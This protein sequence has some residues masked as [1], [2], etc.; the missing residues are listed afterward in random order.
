M[1]DRI[2]QRWGNYRLL[3]LLG[4]G[5]F[6][7]VYLGAHLRL[8]TNAAIKILAT[9]L[10][11]DDQALLFAEAR[12]I[13]RLEHPHI[14][15]ILDFDVENGVPFIVMSYAP[16][17][18]LRQRFPRGTRLPLHLI[19]T[20]LK[21]LADALQ[22]AHEARLI[23]RD[24][25]PENMLLGAHNEILLSD[26]GVAIAARSSH[27]QTLQEI[28]G[29]VTYMAPEQIQGKPRPASDQYALGVIA[30]EWLTGQPPFRGH[31]AEVATQHMFAVPSPPHEQQPEISEQ[32]EAVILKALAKDPHQRFSDVRAFAEA[33][34]Q[35][36][37]RFLSSSNTSLTLPVR[38]E[39]ASSLV[40]LP[41]NK[42][43]S[44]APPQLSRRTI[45]LGSAALAVLVGAGT[46]IAW[47]TLL[48]HTP[49]SQIPQIQSQQAT[50][51]GTAGIG[52]RLITYKGH[53]SPVRSM[54]WSPDDQHI[55]SG[56]DF[57]DRTAQVWNPNTGKRVL[58][59]VGQQSEIQALAWS[60]A[61]Q[62][63]ASGCGN[64]L[65]QGEHTVHIWSAI[66]GKHIVTYTGHTQPIMAVAWSPDGKTVA[67]AGAD[68]T[69]QIW[70]TTSAKILRIYTGHQDSVHA[71]AWSS[72]GK[73]IASASDD[74]TV[75]I[76]NAQ[77]AAHLLTLTHQNTVNAV[78][79]SPDNKLIASGAGSI[80]GGAYGVHVWNAMTGAAILSYQG[81]LASVN[82][83]AWSPD[84]KMIASGSSDKTVQIWQAGDGA[85]IYTYHGHTLRVNVVAWSP[86]GK[87]IASASE[88]G[89]VQ[90]WRS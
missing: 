40:T 72:D 35:A 71:V 28:A 2:G 8:E 5:G 23:H 90:V 59:Y 86:N 84:G 18:N 88:D 31:S 43:R 49:P 41:S 50:P 74:K 34:E 79:W 19:C 77:T 55:V 6:A 65:F 22:Y 57:F 61:G 60:H 39:G 81:H 80:F 56:G 48:P 76:W 67:S 1:I 11:S 62:R 64:A 68:K 66:T 89:T 46:G 54:A 12:T 38:E 78:A 36:S 9:N 85:P 47:S 14:I 20:Y 70:N 42:Q 51:T 58:T 16:N 26:F 4:Q 24:I 21:Q 17:G 25:K 13:A 69:V 87:R 53:K 44:A 83:V 82:T 73:L 3:R 63:I 33:F 32:L 27:A 75:Q 45:V 7:Q 52:G 29:T 10:S 15:R 37:Q 30:Y